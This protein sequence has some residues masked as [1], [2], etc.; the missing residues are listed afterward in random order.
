MFLRAIAV[1][2]IFLFSFQADGAYSATKIGEKIP[3]QLDLVNHRGESVS[4]ESLKGEKGLVVFFVRS[5]DW[6]PFCKNQMMDFGKYYMSFKDIG[7]E[8]VSVSYDPVSVL[9]RFADNKAIPYPMLSDTKSESIKAFGI[10]NK[11][12]KKASRFYGIPN[13]AVYV[14]GADGIVTHM[15]SEGGYQSRPPIGGILRAIE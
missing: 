11:K 1:I 3:H 9:K 15:F 10:R 2:S 6:C 5:A 8:V 12:Y 14:I 13:P 7:Y 4:F